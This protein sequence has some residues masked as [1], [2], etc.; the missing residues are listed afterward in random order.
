MFAP[1]VDVWPS[2][3]CDGCS[4]FVDN[5]GH[6]AHLHARNTSFV[7]VSLAPP[8]QI[9]SYNERM[10]WAVSPEPELRTR[11]SSIQLPATRTPNPKPDT[12]SAPPQRT[13]VA[14]KM[15]LGIPPSSATRAR[16][17]PRRAEWLTRTFLLPSSTSSTRRIAASSGSTTLGRWRRLEPSCQRFLRRGDRPRVRATY[18]PA[19]TPSQTVLNALANVVLLSRRCHEERSEVRNAI[20]K[21]DVVVVGPSAGAFVFPV[22]AERCGHCGSHRSRICPVVKLQFGLV[23]KRNTRM[24]HREN[25]LLAAPLGKFYPTFY[26]TQRI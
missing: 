15:M 1:E 2:A 24:R 25:S 19:D 14:P 12:I 6:L 11:S 20:G 4:M 21:L 7:L 22:T 26:R 17:F 8:A 23:D 16:T 5:V 10:G 9:E 3:G 18:G 13:P